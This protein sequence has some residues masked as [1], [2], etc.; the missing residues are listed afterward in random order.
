MDCFMVDF[1]SVVHSFHKCDRD[2]A[3]DTKGN[4]KH[5]LPTGA[6]NL[7]VKQREVN[8]RHNTMWPKHYQRFAQCGEGAAGWPYDTAVGWP[9]GSLR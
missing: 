5:L 1:I 7:L 3:E 4:K 6:H 8:S 9:G 2:C